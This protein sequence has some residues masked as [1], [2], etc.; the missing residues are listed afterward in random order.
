MSYK[1]EDVDTY[2]I[3]PNFIDTGTV[4]GGM[5]KLRNGHYRSGNRAAGVPFTPIPH[6]K[7]HYCLC[8]GAP[9]GELKGNRVERNFS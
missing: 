2:I 7:N 5:F 1:R 8:Y 3:P 9:A 4:F 6:H